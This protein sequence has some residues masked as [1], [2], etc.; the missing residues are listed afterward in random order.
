MKEDKG[1]GGG[2]IGYKR[3]QSVTKEW[4]GDFLVPF[5]LSS[6]KHK[7]SVYGL[8]LPFYSDF[9]LDKAKQR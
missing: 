9:S 8:V 3:C 2:T 7:R 4:A 5:N 6:M 1:E